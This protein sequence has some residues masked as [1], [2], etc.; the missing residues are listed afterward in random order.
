MF[1]HGWWIAGIRLGK[2]RGGT[3]DWECDDLSV[4]WDNR[5]S[6]DT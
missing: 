5:E 4:V 6:Y 2:T 1:I 3:E